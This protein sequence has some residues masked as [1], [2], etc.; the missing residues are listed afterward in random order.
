M[1][2]AGPRGK[3]DEI[4]PHSQFFEK[5]LFMKMNSDKNLSENFKMCFDFRN[6][7]LGCSYSFV[8]MRK[9]IQI[10]VLC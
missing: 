10:D 1:G 3:G 7:F 2:G 9:D 6:L 8:C 5:K 4:G